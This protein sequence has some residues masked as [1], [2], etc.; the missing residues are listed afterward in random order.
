MKNS[1]TLQDQS[2]ERVAGR[3]TGLK[4]QLSSQALINNI[5]INKM[6]PLRTSR[7]KSKEII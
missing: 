1:T 7:G 4:K 2:Q 6:I 3:D 5:I